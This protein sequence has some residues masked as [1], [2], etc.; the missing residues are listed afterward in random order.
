MGFRYED[1]TVGKDVL[2]FIDAVY[3]TTASFPSEEK[4]GLTSQLRR[5]AQSIFLNLAE[6]SA[7]RTKKEFTRF[8]TIAMGSLVEVHAGF[9]IALRRAYIDQKVWNQIDVRAN[10]LWMRLSSLRDSQK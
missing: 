5:A 2:D 8:I 6:G 4:Y 7:R 3:G 1:L 9:K 10:F